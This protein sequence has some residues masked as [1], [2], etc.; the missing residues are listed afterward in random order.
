MRRRSPAGKRWIALGE[1]LARGKRL[2]GLLPVEDVLLYGRK[3]VLV[4]THF[5]MTDISG[6]GNIRDIVEQTTSAFES[7]SLAHSKGISINLWPY[8][9]PKTD[10]EFTEA[11]FACSY[12]FWADDP[13]IQ[14]WPSPGCKVPLEEPA[15]APIFGRP[16]PRR[17]TTRLPPEPENLCPP[18][19][20]AYPSAGPMDL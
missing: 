18:E 9:D 16:F 8:I 2:P 20:I 7:L 1:E 13:M 12:G 5:Q 15:Y 3:S 11:S 17:I 10:L 6:G 14:D 4:I 19:R